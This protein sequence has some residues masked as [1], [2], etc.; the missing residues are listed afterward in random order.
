MCTT[1]LREEPRTPATPISHRGLLRMC[2]WCKRIARSEVDW[3]EIEAAAVDLGFFERTE[4]AKS[5]MGSAQIARG[6]Y[7]KRSALV[8]RFEDFNS[9]NGRFL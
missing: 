6:C 9:V 5:L 4:P 1:L 7:S 3:V 2:S 8:V